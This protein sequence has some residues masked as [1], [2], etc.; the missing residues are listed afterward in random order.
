MN[1]L[2]L[3]K[4]K[5]TLHSEWKT[6]IVTTNSP[7][8][9][10]HSEY[11]W[12]A[13]LDSIK[14]IYVVLLMNYKGITEYHKFEASLSS[15]KIRITISFFSHDYNNSNIV[16]ISFYQSNNL[17]GSGLRINI[18]NEEL[19]TNPKKLTEI[20]IKENE[21]L[22]TGELINLASIKIGIRLQLL[23]INKDDT[24]ISHGRWKIKKSLLERV[25]KNNFPY[26]F[27]GQHIG[28]FN[29]G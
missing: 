15:T 8:L 11:Y 12:Q 2:K 23:I 26:L 25:N 29:S 24:E 21:E 7:K 1:S 17:S 4:H 19:K 14:E 9:I 10:P 20:I 28:K 13:Q 5:A 16:G 3:T 22:F 27:K 6:K 18:D